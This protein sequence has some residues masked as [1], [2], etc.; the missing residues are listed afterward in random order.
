MVHGHGQVSDVALPVGRGE[1]GGGALAA[2]HRGLG[3]P[4]P[5]GLKLGT[6]GQQVVDGLNRLHD[7]MDVVGVSQVLWIKKENG[8][9]HWQ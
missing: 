6:R 7:G 9:N 1:E 4:V 2:W 8:N 3:Q 5:K